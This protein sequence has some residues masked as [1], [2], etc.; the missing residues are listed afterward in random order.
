STATAYNSVNVQRSLIAGA[1]ST[2]NANNFSAFA[3]NLD[4]LGSTAIAHN[5]INIQDSTVSKATT[6]TALAVAPDLPGLYYS[7]SAFSVD[8]TSCVAISDNMVTMLNSSSQSSA[9]ATSFNEECVNCFAQSWNR[10]QLLN[11]STMTNDSFACASN[12]A[13]NCGQETVVLPAPG[14]V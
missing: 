10:V 4:T 12:G 1:D 2:I 13:L 3:T 5:Y 8:C 6:V 9:F 7:S 14:D 11:D